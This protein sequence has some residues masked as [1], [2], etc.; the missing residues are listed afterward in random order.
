MTDRATEKRLRAVEK[1]LG[2]TGNSLEHLSDLDL[3]AAIGMVAEHLAAEGNADAAADLARHDARGGR[4]T[5]FLRA[6]RC[7]RHLPP[8]AGARRALAVPAG[9]GAVAGDELWAGRA[10]VSGERGRAVGQADTGARSTGSGRSMME[11]TQMTHRLRHRIGRLEQESQQQR[12]I[13]MSVAVRRAGSR[14]PGRRGAGRGR[15]RRRPNDL[16]IKTLSYF[17][18]PGDPPVR[19]VSAAPTPGGH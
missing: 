16:L 18:K 6:T 17:T 10:T 15:R 8:D 9:Q 2:V 11:D 5:G 4:G 1:R 13:V 14:R 7:C 19:L 3:F 12:V